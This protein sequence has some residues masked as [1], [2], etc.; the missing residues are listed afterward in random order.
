MTQHP[1]DTD[2]PAAE[3]FLSSCD[4][5]FQWVEVGDV[6]GKYELTDR[7]GEGATS[8]VFLGRH[9]KLL[10]PVAVKVLDRTSLMATPNLLRQLVSE[11]IL[12]AR[13]NHPNIVRLWDLDDEAQYPYLVLEYVPGGT[14]ADLIRQ[15]GAIPIPYAFAIVR[16]AVEGLAEAY[17]L[18]IVHRDV[19]PGNFLLGR[20]GIVKVADLGLAMVTGD[21]RLRGSAAGIGDLVPAGTTA[22]IAP[23]QA[24]EPKTVDFRADIY[25]L[26]A[27]LYHA[28][29][30]RPVFNGRSSIEVIVKH[31]QE[32]PVSPRDLVPDLSRDCADVI[33]RMLAK[34]PEDRFATY[35]DLRLALAQS[36]GDRRA[37]RP[38]ADSFLSFAA[39][40]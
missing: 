34:R 29:T 14:L 13:L 22:Y 26:G 23:E 18:G 10:F 24:S 25:S 2:H 1:D 19:K 37:P 9:R 31:F 36:L 40:K 16:Q 17:R 15:K 11:A 4:H 20:D 21:R 32:A 5:E 6:L 7:L 12:L 38:L 39:V 33:L 28:V 8:V 35:D 30:G 27:T 3:H